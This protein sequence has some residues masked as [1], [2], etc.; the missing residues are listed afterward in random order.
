MMATVALK[1]LLPYQMRL[2]FWTPQ[3][4]DSINS[5]GS[6]NDISLA[7]FSS[8]VLLLLLFCCSKWVRG[9][10]GAN[11]DTTAKCLGSWSSYVG[12]RPING[13]SKK[14]FNNLTFIFYEFLSFCY[15]WRIISGLPVRLLGFNLQI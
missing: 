7:F 12:D 9:R 1:M 15:L 8:S 3:L 6:E 14:K 2:E 13:L 4:N 5:N 10:E 11:L